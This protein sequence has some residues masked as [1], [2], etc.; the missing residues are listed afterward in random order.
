[1]E[2]LKPILWVLFLVATMG[3][4]ALAKAIEIKKKAEKEPMQ[5]K[6]PQV[7]LPEIPKMR[8]NRPRTQ[9][10]NDMKAQ[11]SASQVSKAI[12]SLHVEQEE[13]LAGD[14]TAEEAA[15]EH[16]MTDFDL[17]KAVIYAEILKPK[18]EE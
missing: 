12:E 6:D 14:L 4:S 1:M 18:F 10:S 3:I 11:N 17:R 16:L 8:Q 15:P 7:V 13:I 5:E 2:D 9:L